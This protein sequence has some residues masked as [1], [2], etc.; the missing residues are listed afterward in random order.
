MVRGVD[1]PARA[2]AI[3]AARRVTMGPRQTGQCRARPGARRPSSDRTPT[4]I[5]RWKLPLIRAVSDRPSSA[6]PC[7]RPPA[8]WFGLRIGDGGRSSSPVL[9][10][11]EPGA[12]LV[13]GVR[14]FP[15]GRRSRNRGQ[16]RSRAGRAHRHAPN[17]E[18]RNQRVQAYPRVPQETLPNVFTSP[19]PTA[20]QFRPLLAKLE[21]PT[22]VMHGAA[23][24]ATRWNPAANS[25]R[26]SLALN[27]TLSRAAAIYAWG[28][29]ARA[30]DAPYRTRRA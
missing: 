19:D 3:V 1:R 2:D 17:R 18:P 26:A 16:G 11:G 30:T 25:P 8:H 27:S 6:S 13:A 5:A 20:A 9:V 22:L 15:K 24:R 23:D 21:L 10:G 14:L 7:R 29:R 4:A 28:G 12:D